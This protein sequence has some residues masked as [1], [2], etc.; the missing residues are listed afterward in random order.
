[1]I[2]KIPYLSPF[3]QFIIVVFLLWWMVMGYIMYI[4]SPF[5]SQTHKLLTKWWIGRIMMYVSLVWMICITS[6]LYDNF[7]FFNNIST[8]SISVMYCLTI[9]IMINLGFISEKLN[10][11]PRSN[12]TGNYIFY[13]MHWLILINL[14]YEPICR[15]VFTSKT[16][17]FILSNIW[18]INIGLNFVF[19]VKFTQF[20]GFQVFASMLICFFQVE[21]FNIDA[22]KNNYNMSYVLTLFIVHLI[23]I[24]I[25]QLQ[26]KKGSHF[27]LPSKWK[28]RVYQKYLKKCT[29]LEENL[30]CEIWTN[31]LNEPE[32]DYIAEQNLNYIKM[33]IGTYIELPWNHKFHFNCILK[34]SLNTER[35]TQW[36]QQ[37]KLLEFDD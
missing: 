10:N 1:M 4:H 16:L 12:Q 35:C 20:V 22:S 25:L 33:E 23:Q 6:Y 30:V 3:T 11:N 13:F 27:W 28:P 37:I 7:K 34:Q 21:Y 14:I 36:D 5:I 32:L 9:A 24:W 26:N 31:K 19:R 2:E 15:Y 17:Y 18:M 8:I 29:D